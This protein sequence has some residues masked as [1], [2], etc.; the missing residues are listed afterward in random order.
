M[1]AAKEEGGTARGHSRVKSR[2]TSCAARAY[3]LFLRLHLRQWEKFPN[4]E[5]DG[6]VHLSAGDRGRGRAGRS[7]K[8]S[9][10][11]C[12][13]GHYLS[14][15]GDSDS[16][17]LTSPSNRRR[18]PWQV[19]TAR[20]AAAAT[21][22]RVGAKES[23]I[24]SRRRR[25]AS[26]PKCHV[27]VEC[28]EGNELATA[29][30]PLHYTGPA[31]N[32]EEKMNERTQGRTGGS[33]ANWILPPPWRCCTIVRELVNESEEPKYDCE[34]K[35]GCRAGPGRMTWCSG[36]LKSSFKMSGFSQN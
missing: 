29:L 2:G 24:S 16:P 13:E 10:S 21:A 19:E 35:L 20:A 28:G 3:R 36:W 14:A 34:E 8:R 4:H 7:R 12:N 1:H 33:E 30:V 27:E 25:R 15:K 17:T 26:M 18:F 11:R 32:R 31:E 5:D 23:L 22:S 6:R 9:Y